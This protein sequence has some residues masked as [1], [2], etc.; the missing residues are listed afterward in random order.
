MNKRNIQPYMFKMY[1]SKE[2]SYS[3]ILNSNIK[4]KK[5]KTKIIYIFTKKI[6]C[7]AVSNRGKLNTFPIEKLSKGLI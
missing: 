1:F 4:G 5:C 6:S 3:T 2:I 7:I